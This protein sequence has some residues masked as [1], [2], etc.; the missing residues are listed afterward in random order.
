[1]ANT[2]RSYYMHW[3][4]DAVF[5]KKCLG[6]QKIGCHLCQ[7][8]FKK[9]TFH[10]KLIC[11]DCNKPLTVLASHP[12]CQTNLSGLLTV[13]DWQ[14]TLLKN[15]IY[16]FKYNF[17]KSLDI[18][19]G[20]LLTRGLQHKKF[21]WRNSSPLLLPVPLH[22]RRLRWRGF[23]QAELLAKQIGQKFDWPAINNLVIRKKH[24]KPQMSIKDTGSRK[25]NIHAVFAINT[26]QENKYLLLSKRTIFIVDDVCTTG[27]TLEEIASCLKHRHKNL[28]IYGLVLARA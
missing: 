26:Q 15:L 5:P 8:C 24:T 10:P 17:I 11:T 19:L 25:K 13:G 3:I 6:C 22:P 12:T 23:N 20:K 16:N 14:D 28:K 7:S 9:I 18:P 4:W 21:L 27:S 1:M 2:T